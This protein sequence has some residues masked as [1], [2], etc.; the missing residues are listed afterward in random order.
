[1]ASRV[2][3]RRPLVIRDAEFFNIELSPVADGTFHLS[4]TAT[5]VDDRAPQLL[6]QDIMFTSAPT[7]EKALA[8]IRQGLIAPA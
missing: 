5:T 3:K 7:L 8:K 4:I 2:K 6:T 1:M